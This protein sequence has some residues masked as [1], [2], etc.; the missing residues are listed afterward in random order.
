MA[1]RL[2]RFKERLL[3][4]RYFRVAWFAKDR[5][6]Q[7]VTQ[8]S[9]SK[10]PDDIAEALV[11][12]TNELSIHPREKEV[13]LEALN[14]AITDWQERPHVAI[15]SMVIL[16]HPVSAV[17][18]ILACSLEQ[19]EIHEEALRP[20]NL[21][22]W[23]E[24]PP[25]M[26]SIQAQ[27][28]QKLSRAEDKR[29]PNANGDGNADELTPQN[30]AVIPNLCWCFLRSAEGLEGADYLR[31]SLLGDRTQFWVIGSGQVGW[32]YLKAT[33]K[34]HAYCGET[35]SLPNLTGEELQDWLAPIVEQFEI[36]FEDSSLHK[37]FQHPE[38]LKDL[39][40]S[41]DK[42]VESISEITQE[43]SATV[44]SSL[45]AVK[46]EM[47]PHEPKDEDTNLKRDYF[48]RLADISDGVSIVAVQLFIKSLR[49]QAPEDADDDKS[50]DDKPEQEESNSKDRQ[51][52]A[53]EKRR[54]DV[55]IPVAPSS[56][57]SESLNEP[58]LVATTPKLPTLPDFD[59]SDLYLLYSLMLHGDLTVKALAASLG[60]APQV[61]NN[62]VQ[63][64]RNAG[65]IE[66]QEAV[67]KINP[68]HYPQLQRELSRNN[69]MIEVP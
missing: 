50:E 43:V 57:S 59:Q 40:I 39:N 48:D 14:E 33:L 47:L 37:R 34:F 52:K 58:R 15:N 7:S 49:Y 66:Q 19:L 25:D 11:T 10:L 4:Q 68:V 21:L 28:E 64:L 42:P 61:V 45:R 51:R 30:L 29:S 18:R 38:R 24:R 2:L 55:S 23:I 46:G 26:S 8:T 35:V 41:A 44:K 31:D 5:Q 69:F 16:G 17:S 53:L 62:Q 9:L 36:C 22:D 6:I 12:A 27:I 20:V 63:V 32:E 3:E 67:I 56:E 1:N 60:D 54:N 13:V 65:I